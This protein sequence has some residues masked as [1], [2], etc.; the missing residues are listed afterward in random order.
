VTNLKHSNN[1]IL[2]DLNSVKLTSKFILLEWCFFVEE[3]VPNRWRKTCS[4]EWLAW[5]MWHFI[6]SQNRRTACTSAE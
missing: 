2:N 4:W 1:Q 5:R 6:E 3:E